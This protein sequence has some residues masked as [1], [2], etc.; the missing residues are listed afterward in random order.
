MRHVR[1][2]LLWSSITELQARGH[3]DAYLANLPPSVA[4]VVSTTVAAT[5]LP[6][7]IGD[8]HFAACEALDLPRDVAVEIGSSSCRRLQQSLLNSFLFLA[9]GAADPLALFPAYPRVWGRYF[10]GGGM[11][12]YQVGPKEVHLE[13]KEIPFFRYRYCHHAIRGMT[14]ALVTLFHEKASV[15]EVAATSTSVA[16]RVAWA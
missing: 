16:V 13:L 3:Y 15:R 9:R 2:T 8:A 10:D 7:E 11:V 6:I 1:S 4:E 14:Q 5:W 12:A